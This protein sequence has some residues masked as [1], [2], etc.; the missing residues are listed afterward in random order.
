M[1]FDS[2]VFVVTGAA[3]GIGAAVVRAARSQAAQVLALDM[4]AHNGAEIEAQTGA[5]FMRCDVGD[6]EDWARVARLVTDEYGAIDFLHL[7]AGIQ[8]APPEVDLTEYQFEN[9]TLERYRKLTSVNI[10][11]VVFGLHFLLPLMNEG[12]A[13]VATSS[14]A[15]IVPYE[16]DPLYSMT[17]HA[18]SG[19][20]RSL[21]GSLAK[22]N[23]KI[24]AICPGGID[25]AII[26]HQQRSDTANF[27]TA[28][29]VAAEV[30]HLMSV[31]ETG[32]TWAKVR[33][34]KPV[35]II[36]APG[37]REDQ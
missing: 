30:L 4:D 9:M 14:L 29:N 24:N 21:G 35:F 32:K 11:G 22:R 15:G 34:D 3:S 17:K 2:K 25:T 10:D 28:E 8:S 18:V 1:R 5:R 19:L 7:N 13:I 6:S 27:M 37:D 12:G 16:I 20:V 23:I 33:N 31:A 36:R 26:P